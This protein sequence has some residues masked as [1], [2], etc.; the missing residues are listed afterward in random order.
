MEKRDKRESVEGPRPVLVDSFILFSFHTISGCVCVSITSKSKTIQGEMESV[1][2]EA[3]GETLGWNWGAG[4]D[5]QY[6]LGVD[7]E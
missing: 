1:S 4:R 3:C 6:L 5:F 2:I 7:M